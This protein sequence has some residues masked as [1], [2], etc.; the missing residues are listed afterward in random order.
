M[1]A[2]VDP[3][4]WRKLL[5]QAN[6]GQLSLDPEIGQGLSKVCDEYLN[7]LNDIMKTTGRLKYLGGFGS[8]Q[9]GIDLEQKFKTK[10]FGTDRSI[11]AIL[12]QHMDVVKTAKEVVAKAI[13]NFTEVE[14]QN[15]ARITKAGE[16]K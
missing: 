8:F 3:D 5:G 7:S 2:G 9:S 6:S 1:V 12:Q 16:Q 10:A 13:S 4:A 14:R 15:A 11:D